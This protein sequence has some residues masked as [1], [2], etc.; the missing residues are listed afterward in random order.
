MWPDHGMEVVVLSDASDHADW[1]LVVATA[2]T[3]H[4]Q[5]T[6]TLKLLL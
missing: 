5:T 4:T 2:V 1:F 3:E 6:D